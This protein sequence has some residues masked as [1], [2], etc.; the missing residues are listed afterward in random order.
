MKT[1]TNKINNLIDK[2]MHTKFH[3]GWV[4]GVL[5]GIMGLLVY[6]LAQQL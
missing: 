3:I 5:L 4:F 2:I 6:L 1:N